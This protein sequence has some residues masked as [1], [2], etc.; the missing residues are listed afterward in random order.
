MAVAVLCSLWS[1][2]ELCTQHTSAL[3]CPSQET[4]LWNIKKYLNAQFQS[5]TP[6]RLNDRNLPGLTGVTSVSVLRGESPKAWK[7]AHNAWMVEG[8]SAQLL[9]GM[10]QKLCTHKSLMTRVKFS[11]KTSM[12]DFHHMISKFKVSGVHALFTSTDNNN[13]T[14]NKNNAHLACLS[15]NGP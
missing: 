6:Q 10:K 15:H 11:L 13:D 5:D 7:F 1:H 8:H 12:Q 4:D 3:H 9:L 14:K 2:P